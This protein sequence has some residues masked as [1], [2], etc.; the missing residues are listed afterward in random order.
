MTEQIKNERAG[1]IFG[2]NQ[3]EKLNIENTLTENRE[4]GSEWLV[5]ECS[6][7]NDHIYRMLIVEGRCTKL[8][9]LIS[10]IYDHWLTQ[11][12]SEF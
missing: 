12:Y 5:V 7:C 10:Y 9:L 2:G 6:K 8:Q 3:T 4:A 1:N 11:K